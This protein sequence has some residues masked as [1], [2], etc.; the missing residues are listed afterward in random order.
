MEGDLLLSEDD[1]KS[2]V[3]TLL[4]TRCYQMGKPKKIMKLDYCE[5]PELCQQVHS[6]LSVNY[7]DFWSSIDLTFLS[8]N[9]DEFGSE[10]SF[11]TPLDDK[12]T[13]Y[14]TYEDKKGKILPMIEVDLAEM[15]GPAMGK[16]MVEKMFKKKVKKVLKNV[17]KDVSSRL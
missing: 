16:K 3:F 12:I 11:S 9:Y 2:S 17:H 8:S 13:M 15:G 14:L 5:I 7:Y 6:E 4:T 1:K 10:Y